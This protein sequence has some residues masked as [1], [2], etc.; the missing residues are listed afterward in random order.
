MTNNHTIELPNPIPKNLN[1]GCGWD[2]RPGFLNVDL[3]SIH[4]PD[5]VA[6]VCDLSMLPTAYF[7]EILAQDV[8]EHLER[9]KTGI[10][11]KEWERL[12][13]LNGK[14]LIRVPSLFGMFELL[15]RA[16]YR[17]A[18]NAEKIIHLIYGTQAYNGDYHLTGFTAATLVEHLRLAG[19]QVSRCVMKDDWLFDVEV[20]KL[21]SMLSDEEFVHNA[22]FSILGRPA[23][24]AGVRHFKSELERGTSREVIADEIQGSAES[25][26]FKYN[27]AYLRSNWQYSPNVNITSVGRVIRK[28]IRQFI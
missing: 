12:L 23:D 6:D 13:S 21:V 19:M 17:N 27:P 11:L 9:A 5:L 1:L 28:F 16:E 25:I 15:S 26:F 7:N 8:L 14:L 18:E 24:T 2:K 22:F 10:A 4:S 20:K 3:H